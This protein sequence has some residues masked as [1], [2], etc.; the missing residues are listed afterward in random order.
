[1]VVKNMIAPST[2]RGTR[3][4]VRL[5]VEMHVEGEKRAVCHDGQ[6]AVLSDRGTFIDAHGDYPLDSMVMLRFGFPLIDDI[7]CAG[8]VRDC[9]PDG[10][11]V[12]FLNLS[13]G[14]RAQLGELVLQGGL[15]ERARQP[16]V[17]S[18]DGKPRIL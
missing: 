10:I 12:E 16:A 9:L 2:R 7:I 15:S 11:G 13:D 5:L 6:V 1:M 17:V 8:V 18:P 14:E 3:V 4:K